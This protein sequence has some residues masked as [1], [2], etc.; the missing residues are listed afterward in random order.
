MKPLTKILGVISAGVLEALPS[1]A[2]GLVLHVMNDGNSEVW[3]TL[4]GKIP[5]WPAPH[6]L[7]DFRIPAKSTNDFYLDDSSSLWPSFS[8]PSKYPVTISCI[9]TPAN[10]RGS[11]S[12]RYVV[13]SGGQID[14][15]VPFRRVVAVFARVRQPDGSFKTKIIRFRK[16]E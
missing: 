15:P 13:G 8:D 16:V 1:H 14:L 7:F 12:C 5:Q 11:W 10:L 6:G 4:T 3:G 9:I 2:A